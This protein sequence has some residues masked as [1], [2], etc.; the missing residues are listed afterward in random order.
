VKYGGSTTNPGSPISQAYW[1]NTSTTSSAIGKA[2]T[3]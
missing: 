2:G 1:I 3:I